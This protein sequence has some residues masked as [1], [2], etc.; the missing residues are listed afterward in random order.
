MDLDSLRKYAERYA[1][2]STIDQLKNMINLSPGVV[3]L[4]ESARSKLNDLAQSGL[5]DIKFYQYAEL[6][7]ENI[8]NINL[9]H[10]ASELRNIATKL[11]EGQDAVRDSLLK[12]AHDLEHYHRDLVMPMAALSEQLSNSALTLQ[13]HIKFNHPSMAEAIHN[14]VEEVKKAQQFL[15]E[16]GPQ[17]VQF[18]SV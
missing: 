12:N 18:V 17:Y 7:K 9:E 10:L 16:D 6:L 3:I 1:I 11:P 14:L 5:S 15:N 2:S 8:T 4:S 13:E